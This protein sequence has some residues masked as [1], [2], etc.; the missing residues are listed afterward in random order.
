MTQISVYKYIKLEQ[1][2]ISTLIKSESV[3]AKEADEILSFT[4]LCVER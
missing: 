3:Y 2:L 1:K 4:I